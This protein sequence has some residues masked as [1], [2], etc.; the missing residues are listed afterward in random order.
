LDSKTTLFWT[1]KQCRFAKNGVVVTIKFIYLFF[2]KRKFLKKKKRRR[3]K[4]R[5][6]WAKMGWLDH[7]IFG[8]WVARATPRQVWG[9]SNVPAY[10]T[11]SGRL[12]FNQPGDFHA[13]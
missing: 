3:R 1:P 8:Q 7:P 13:D 9:W 10:N 11:T 4:S 5:G 6:G 2:K 12:K